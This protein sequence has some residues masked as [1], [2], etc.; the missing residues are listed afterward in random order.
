LK[1]LKKNDEN[2]TFSVSAGDLAAF[3]LKV[4]K[5]KKTK[6]LYFLSLVSLF[7]FLAFPSLSFV[8]SLVFPCFSCPRFPSSFS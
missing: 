3:S 6:K 4:S 5:H 8:L 7:L 2:E 1:S